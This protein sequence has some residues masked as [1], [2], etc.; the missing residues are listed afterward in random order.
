MTQV[1]KLLTNCTKQTENY[2]YTLTTIKVYTIQ[3]DQHSVYNALLLA[4][5]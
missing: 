1:K 5:R 4:E 3:Y 2:S